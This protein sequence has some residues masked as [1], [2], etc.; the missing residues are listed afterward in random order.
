MICRSKSPHVFIKKGVLLQL[1]SIITEEYPCGTFPWM[2]SC[3]LAKYTHTFLE[4]TS[5]WLLLYIQT[6]YKISLA[7]S[8]FH[9]K[10]T[11]TTKVAS[12]W[13]P[14]R[15]LWADFTSCSSAFLFDIEYVKLDLIKFYSF[16]KCFL[17]RKN[18]HHRQ[19]SDPQIIYDG[20]LCGN[21]ISG[22]HFPLA[23]QLQLRW[24]RNRKAASVCYHLQF[25]WE[26]WKHG[27]GEKSRGLQ[28]IT[29][30]YLISFLGARE[31]SSLLS[32]LKSG[33]F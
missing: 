21:V 17:Q 11:R 24:R 18:T 16:W 1:R 13:C 10:D 6:G 22:S 28:H 33:S 31:N 29:Y 26:N 30:W 7:L 15:E 4:N 5:G 2:L 12:F 23:K 9:N 25:P 3:K 19:I 32:L 8:A 20:A 27:R 14:N